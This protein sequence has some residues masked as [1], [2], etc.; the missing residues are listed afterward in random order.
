MLSHK[1]CSSWEGVSSACEL[2]HPATPSTSWS[3]LGD[4]APGWF[5]D[6]LLQRTTSGLQ[7]GCHSYPFSMCPHY[8]LPLF[9]KYWAH[10]LQAAMRGLCYIFVIFRGT[11]MLAGPYQQMLPP[12]SL[13]GAPCSSLPITGSGT[14]HSLYLWALRLFDLFSCR[15]LAAL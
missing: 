13:H 6:S 15:T 10:H 4:L 3:E 11:P 9:T 2:S 7:R 12:H 8:P 14:W 1:H 5:A